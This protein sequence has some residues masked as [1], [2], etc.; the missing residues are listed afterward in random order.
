MIS[1]VMLQVDWGES[2]M[3]EAERLLLQSALENPANQRFI[4]LSDR[5][6]SCYKNLQQ[7]TILPFFTANDHF[8]LLHMYVL[9][10][11]F[12]LDTPTLQSCLR[13]CLG[14]YYGFDTNCNT[15]KF[16]QFLKLLKC[17]Q[18]WSPNGY[19]KNMLSKQI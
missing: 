10:V 6:D 1:V 2:T 7:M 13:P 14:C 11:I 19:F 4:L 18:K 17:L 5:L 9:N 15:P 16:Q 8:T 3:I 12:F